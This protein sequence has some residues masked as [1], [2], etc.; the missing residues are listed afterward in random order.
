MAL[1]LVDVSR[2][3]AQES[4]S[5]ALAKELVTLMGERKLDAFAVQDPA[6][7]GYF[8][9]VR[10]YP[11]IQLLIVGAQSSSVDYVK[12]QLDRKDYG[13]VYS[14]LNAS[15]VPETKVFVQDMG[16]DGVRREGDPVDVVYHQAATQILLDGTGKASGL[17]KSAYAAKATELDVR[18][19]DLLRVV[20]ET[21]RAAAAGEEPG[22]DPVRHIPRGA[23]PI[24]DSSGSAPR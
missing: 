23:A 16:C 17:S 21:I 15:A 8:V 18:Y 4:K 7:P 20:L 19:A 5:A 3:D 24:L 13:E 12:Y 6:T 11:D 14:A 9:A 1:A 22:R 2:A 10:P